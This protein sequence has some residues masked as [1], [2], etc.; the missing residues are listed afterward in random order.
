MWHRPGRGVHPPSIETGK[1]EHRSART[2]PAPGVSAPFMLVCRL[3]SG[4]V[5]GHTAIRWRPG[6]DKRHG[7]PAEEASEAMT[8]ALTGRFSNPVK[9]ERPSTRVQRPV[10]DK[11]PLLPGEAAA[12]PSAAEGVGFEPTVSFPTHAFQACRFGRS[13]IPPE[14][15]RG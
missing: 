7:L 5:K 8:A 3:M 14:V 10:S 13:R 1:R 2:A 15:R 4:D 6:S 9:V 12:E 11:H